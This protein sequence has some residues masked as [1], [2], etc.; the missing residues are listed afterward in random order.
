MLYQ[1]ARFRGH[2]QTIRTDQGPEFTGKALDRIGLPAW[3]VVQC[4]PGEQPTQNTFIETFN[5]RF[6]DECLNDHWFMG[7]PQ[8][9]VLIAARRREYNQHRPHSSPDYLTHAEFAAKHRSSYS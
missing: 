1:A 9:R 6:R 4:Y 2:A 5:Y 8:A 7:L 3:R